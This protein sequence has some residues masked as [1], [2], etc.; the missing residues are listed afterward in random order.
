MPNG[1]GWINSSPVG[2]SI[3]ATDGAGSGVNQIRFWVDN[4]ATSSSSSSPASTNV[5]GE[6]QH[7]VGARAIDNA[8]NISALISAAVN[9][10]LTPPVVTVTGVTN[11]ATYPYNSVPTAGCQTTDALSGVST[12]AT[13]NLTG[14]NGEGYGNFTATCSGAQDNAGNT[15]SPVSDSYTVQAPPNVTAKVRITS[16]P[17]AYNKET[18]AIK[19]TSGQSIAGPLQLVLTNLPA[20]VTARNA[21]GTWGGNPYLTISSSSF[22][23]QATVN[24]V[25]D[26]SNPA[27]PPVRPTPA[28]YSATLRN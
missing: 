22:A 8:G 1:N 18:F 27:G 7:T 25:V 4:G 11:N 13:L 9:I 5:S 23:P 26:F 16:H 15:A 20:G 6:G 10:D 24:V 28:V 3:S 14:D 12:P 17:L 19:N 2:A 21:T